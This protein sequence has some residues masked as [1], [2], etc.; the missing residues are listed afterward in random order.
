L[1]R[2]GLVLTGAEVKKLVVEALV[3][4][5]RTVEISRHSYLNGGGLPRTTTLAVN[6][7]LDATI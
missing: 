3:A 1:V 7:V 6:V 5:K 2:V 4:L